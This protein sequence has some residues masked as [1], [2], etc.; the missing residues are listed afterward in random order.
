MTSNSLA[1]AQ[2]FCVQSGLGH[3]PTSHL[4]RLL[5]TVMKEKT[6]LACCTALKW[7]R[8]TIPGRCLDTSWPCAGESNKGEKKGMGHVASGV[9]KETGQ[10]LFFILKRR[11][12]HLS[13]CMGT[14]W[15][16][17]KRF[18]QRRHQVPGTISQIFPSGQSRRR[19]QT[20][21]ATCL[22]FNMFLATHRRLG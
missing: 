18:A 20:Q 21:C 8:I 11:T 16:S 3:T 22:S 4:H 6:G 15:C 14:K 1:C 7:L 10:K 12:A 17:P 13:G 5:S 19:L 2:D 9:S